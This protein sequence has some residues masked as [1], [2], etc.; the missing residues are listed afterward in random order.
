MVTA[1]IRSWKKHPVPGHP[2]VAV[3]TGTIY[4]DAKKRWRDGTRFHTSAV[5]NERE[6]KDY[7]YVQTLNSLYILYKNQEV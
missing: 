7:I 6:S 3:Y 5:V 4:G 1:E 2:D